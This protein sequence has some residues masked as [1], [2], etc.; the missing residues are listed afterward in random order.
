MRMKI[1]NTLIIIAFLL[2]V[3]SCKTVNGVKVANPSKA[4]AYMLQ[5]ATAAKWRFI[6]SYD[7]YN[8]GQTSTPPA[9]NPIYLELFPN[10]T[11]K[12][13]DLH[14]V[15]QGKWYLNPDKNA[16]A[17]MPQPYKAEQKPEFLYKIKKFTA[18][19]LIFSLQGRHGMVDKYYIKSK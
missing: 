10:Q 19:S 18:D 8:G 13:S 2:S 11:Y 16:V 4:N 15:T 12:E 7:P 1:T 6:K 3:A 9:S 5:N 17:F 14:T